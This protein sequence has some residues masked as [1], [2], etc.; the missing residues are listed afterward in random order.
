[1][2]NFREGPVPSP[3]YDDNSNIFSQRTEF[4]DDV[5]IQGQLFIGADKNE[6]EIFETND[7]ITVRNNIIN[8]DVISKKSDPILIYSNKENNQKLMS[9]NS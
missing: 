8:K 1:M 9:N 2:P 7:D 3:S 6:Y 5:F 4:T